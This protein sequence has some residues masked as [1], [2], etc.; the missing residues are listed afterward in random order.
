[1]FQVF[2]V[3]LAVWAFFKE[4]SKR[5]R[6][7]WHIRDSLD[8]KDVFGE[9]SKEAADVIEDFSLF[10]DSSSEDKFSWL[11]DFVDFYLAFFLDLPFAFDV[12]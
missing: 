9:F 10:Y 11:S 12:P 8:V 1:M 5:G 4:G 7:V 6:H 3:F 2:E